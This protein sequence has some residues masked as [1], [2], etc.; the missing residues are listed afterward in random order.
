MTE[1]NPQVSV[2]PIQRFLSKDG[3]K[4]SCVYSD[5]AREGV[6]SF[7][8]G[9]FVAM[10]QKNKAGK[11]ALHIMVIPSYSP[12]YGTTLIKVPGGDDGQD[13]EFPY[14]CA[15]REWSE[16]VGRPY[17]KVSLPAALI[18]MIHFMD[19]PDERFPGGKHRKSFWLLPMR[20]LPNFRNTTVHFRKGD[21]VD[22][23]NVLG[24]PKLVDVAELVLYKSHLRAF[25]LAIRELAKIDVV[26]DVLP[27]GLLQWAML[28]EH[29]VRGQ[30]IYFR[31]AA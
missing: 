2:K 28:P 10:V 24:E 1:N 13:M 15:V 9:T 4:K 7:F 19:L 25:A 29:V 17:S 20:L 16:E 31:P 23:D 26:Y 12:K 8:C 27:D 5:W 22:G 18:K 14:E 21:K 30:P 6:S 11:D 3:T